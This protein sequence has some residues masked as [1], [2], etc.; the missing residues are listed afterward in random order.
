LQNALGVEVADGQA[1]DDH[2]HDAGA[3]HDHEH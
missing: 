2:K 3:L 1:G